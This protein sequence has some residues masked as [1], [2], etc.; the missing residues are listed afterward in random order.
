[1]RVA[2]YSSKTYEKPFF[3]AANIGPR[4]DLVYLDVPLSAATTD[5]ARGCP[6]VSIFVGDDASAQVLCALHKGG[7]RVLALRSAGFNHV[8]IAQ[9]DRLGLMVL[10]VPA[11]SPYAVAEHA[12]GLML[13]LNRKY[14]RA[15][16]RVRE[17][18]FALDGLMGFDMHGKT[19]GVIGTGKIG[20]IVCKILAGFGCRVLAFDPQENPACIGVGAQYVALPELYAGADIITLHCPLTPQTRHLINTAAL[21]A[22]KPGVMLINTS[23]GA[24]IDTRALI[25]ALKKGRIGSVGLDVY[26][27]EGDLFFKDL[28]GEVIQDDVFVRLLTFP[29][30]LITAHQGFFTCEAMTAIAQTTIN[31]VTDF[32]RGTCQESNRVGAGLIAPSPAASRPSNGGTHHAGLLGAG[33]AASLPL[34]P[35]AQA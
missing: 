17:Q 33:V 9:A 15:F 35:K 10:R 20:E 30:V 31:N 3:G 2:V 27:E 29:N 25:A 19:A 8:D 26:E 7:T 28:S 6:A 34:G 16:N 13:A 23:R 22:M 5:L 24:V 21:A 14:H 11:Y 18:N 4:H 12:V 32:E 1:M